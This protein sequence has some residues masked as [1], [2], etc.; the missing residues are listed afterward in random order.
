MSQDMPGDINYVFR[1]G[2]ET[3]GKTVTDLPYV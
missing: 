1:Y 2:T 3:G